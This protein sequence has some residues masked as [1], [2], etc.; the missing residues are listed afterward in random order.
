MRTTLRRNR[1]PWQSALS[2]TNFRNADLALDDRVVAP[3][4][5]GVCG[6]DAVSG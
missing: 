1:F 6:I 4:T 2:M 5:A 3:V